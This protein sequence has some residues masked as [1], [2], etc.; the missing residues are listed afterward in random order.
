M[1]TK[2]QKEAGETNEETSECARL[3]WAELHDS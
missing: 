1:H 2:M 3:E